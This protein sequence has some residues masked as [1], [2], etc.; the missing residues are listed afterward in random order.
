MPKNFPASG[1]VKLHTLMADNVSTKSLKSG[2]IRSDLVSFDFDEEQELVHNSFKPMVREGRFDWGELAIVTFLQAKYYGKPLVLLPAVIGGR[3]QHQCIAYNT[4][5]GTLSPGELAGKRIGV[6]SYT[7]TT[8]AW[9]RGILQNEYGVDPATVHWVC[10]EDA[11]LA[12]FSDP[13]NV[14]RAQK[15]K[16]LSQMLLDG[17]LDAAMLGSDMPNDPRL[18]TVIPNPKKD[19]LEWY[20]RRH[21]IPMN[22]MAVVSEDLARQRPDVVRELY[23]MLLESRDLDTKP[24]DG[25]QMRPFGT[26]ALRPALETIITYA[27]QQKIIGRKMSVDEL[28]DDTTRALGN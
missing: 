2:A 17:D 16:K 3:F 7:Q 13:S 26:E 25:L 9:V 27:F 15:G 12:E 20:E 5:R 24:V 6:R 19:A 14:E 4:D 10:F 8:G 23:R 18:K 28:F 11:H 21:V 1:P 22:H